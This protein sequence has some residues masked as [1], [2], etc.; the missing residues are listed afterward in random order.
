[1]KISTATSNGAGSSNA[2]TD[3][4]YAFIGFRYQNS[5]VPHFEQ[6]PRCAQS[7]ESNRV[8]CSSPV[9][10]TPFVRTEKNGEPPAQRRHMPQWQALCLVST[11]SAENVTAPHKHRPVM[12][13]SYGNLRRAA[14]VPRDM[15]LMAV[16]LLVA[17]C[18]SERPPPSEKEF[19]VE[20][21]P[22]VGAKVGAAAT[23]QVRI[24]PGAGYHINTDYPLKVALAKTPGLEAA[25]GDA[26][27][28]ET[29]L[30]LPITVTPTAAGNHELRGTV[31]LGMCKHDQCLQREVPI[32]VQVA[33]N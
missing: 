3:I 6:N 16:C 14:A 15:R 26:R 24:R 28:A 21:V 22:P 4:A 29:E 30:A 13:A 32:A 20:V 10:V 31:T 2:P 7:E 18:S 12:R 9:N 33:V 1:M 19:T 8:M 5:A 23:A 27:T 25:K 17:A 11:P